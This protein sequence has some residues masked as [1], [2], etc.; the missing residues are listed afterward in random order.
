MYNN[1]HIQTILPALFRLSPKINYQRQT[2]NTDDGDFLDLDWVKSMNPK[3]AVIVH[4]LECASD[5][6]YVKA[7]V[8]KLQAAGYD[9]VVINLRGCSGRPNKLLKSYHSGKSEDLASVLKHL[10]AYDEISLIG[11]SIGGNIV[12]KYLGESNVVDSK[13]K[14][15]VA[16]S[17]PVD[18]A[19]SAKALTEP[20]CRIYMQRMLNKL[21][22]KIKIKMKL[23]PG[24]ID[25]SNFAAIKTFADYDNKYTAPFN[26]FKNA[27]DYWRQAS[28]V[29]RLDKI[30]VRTLILSALDDPFLGPECYPQVNNPSIQT[31]YTQYGGHLGFWDIHKYQIRYYYEDM[32]IGF[33]EGDQ[34]V[35]RV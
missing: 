27:E 31:V 24:H 3:L 33:L 22:A 35:N 9:A 21:R 14:A 28:A 19:S 32:I 25:D 26:G 29:N 18:L 7:M 8:R 12:L 1:P 11:F 17:A 4:G 30:S 15:A 5:T 2:I 13:I 16:I 20:S 23:F 6:Y 10:P 34:L